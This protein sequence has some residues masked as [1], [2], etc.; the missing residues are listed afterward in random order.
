MFRRA[1]ASAQAPFGGA[2]FSM[3]SA[4]ASS[5]SAR[6]FQCGGGGCGSGGCGTKARRGTGATSS[7]EQDQYANTAESVRRYMAFREKLGNSRT[8]VLS[9]FI[10]YELVSP[11]VLLK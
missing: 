2:S 11:T 1:L 3:P 10:G 6:R 9:G 8:Y 7:A 4:T 5:F